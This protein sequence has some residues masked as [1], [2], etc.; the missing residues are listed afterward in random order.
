M[1]QYLE[2]LKDVLENGQGI[3]PGE[4]IRDDR[5]GVGTTALFDREMRF[6][7]ADGFP[8]VTTKKVAFE[9]VKAELLWFLT[10]S[11]DVKELQKFGCHIWDANANAEY[12]KMKAE[13]EG[14]VGRI[15]GVQWRKWRRP[16]GT[17]LDQLGECIDR[18]KNK[19]QD[20]RL[21]VLA[22]NP[23]ELQQMCLPPCHAFFQFFVGHGRLSMSMWQRSCDMFLGVPFNTPCYAL[24]LHMIAQ[25]TGWEPGA[26]THHLG[27][28]H[29]YNHPDHMRGV[30]EQLTREPYPLPKLWLN[31]EI[32]NIDDFKMEDIKLI[33]YKHHPAIK[34]PMMV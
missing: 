4:K 3:K 8:I 23:G 22:W 15:Y 5:T 11:R 24:L 13:F 28:F 30:A 1:R 32:K 19:P 2:V 12:W 14:D 26:F 34:A 20:R 33:G 29:I 18:I 17:A 16:D 7:L 31:P 21:L 9:L 25:I 10:G 6:D 27:D